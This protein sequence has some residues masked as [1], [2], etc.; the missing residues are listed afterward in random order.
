MAVDKAK[1][2]RKAAKSYVDEYGPVAVDKAKIAAA[3]AQE[4]ALKAKAAA[5]R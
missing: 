2:A 1:E 3:S 4:A 5:G